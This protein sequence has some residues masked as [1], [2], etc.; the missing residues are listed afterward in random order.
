GR[1]SGHPRLRFG[2]CVAR[3]ARRLISRQSAGSMGRA[4]SYVFR[5]MRLEGMGLKDGIHG[6]AAR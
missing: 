1:D 2:Y 4:I 5:G 6:L 3:N